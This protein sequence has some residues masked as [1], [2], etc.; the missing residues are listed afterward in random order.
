[1]A[2]LPGA[3]RTTDVVDGDPIGEVWTDK[4]SWV[5]HGFEVTNKIEKLKENN[6][7]V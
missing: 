7:N 2:D 1:M 3:D 5:W 6:N 4:Y